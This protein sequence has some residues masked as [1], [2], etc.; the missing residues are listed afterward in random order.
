MIMSEQNPVQ[1]VKDA[2][3]AFSRNDISS[4]IN[5]M[6][7]DVSWYLPGPQTVL[8]FAG[9]RKGK[10]EVNE[11]FSTLADVQDVERF[12]PQDF[13]AQGDK[14][15]ALGNY[16]WRVKATARTYESEFAH[17]FTVREGKIVAF[18]EYFDTAAVMNAFGTPVQSATA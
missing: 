11:F 10:T 14:V 18:H 3:A 2:Y 5:L 7:D 6:A 16:K 8:P 4:L 15:V 17:V 9:R 13:I 1:I 12:E